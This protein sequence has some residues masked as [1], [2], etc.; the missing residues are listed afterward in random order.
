MIY[1]Q[2][3][4]TWCKLLLGVPAGLI[5]GFALKDSTFIITWRTFVATP[6]PCTKSYCQ[7]HCEQLIFNS[8]MIRSY[9]VDQSINK[10]HSFR[11]SNTQLGHVM[12]HGNCCYPLLTRHLS[13]DFWTQIWSIISNSQTSRLLD[14]YLN[15][16]CNVYSY[17]CLHL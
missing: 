12:P 7:S 2:F 3:L 6:H 8:S 9:Y 13:R 11:S 4:K 16:T 14:T 17:N 10:F 1:H 5:K 15:M